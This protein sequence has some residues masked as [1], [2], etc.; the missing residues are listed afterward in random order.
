MENEIKNRETYSVDLRNADNDRTIQSTQSK[1]LLIMTINH[2]KRDSIVWRT[3]EA[4][5]HHNTTPTHQSIFTKTY[6]LVWDSFKFVLHS[7][8]G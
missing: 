4:P 1:L 6:I 5:I 8:Q 7:S 2:G 3:S